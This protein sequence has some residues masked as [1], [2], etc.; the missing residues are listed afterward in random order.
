MVI[1]RLDSIPAATVVAVKDAA[2]QT[3]TQTLKSWLLQASC[4]D[5][6]LP[7]YS[8]FQPDQVSCLAVIVTFNAVC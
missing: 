4:D 1:E 3:V 7:L 8:T 5:L 2:A 6:T